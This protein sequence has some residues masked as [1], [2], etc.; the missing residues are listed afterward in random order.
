MFTAA[1]I[2]CLLFIFRFLIAAMKTFGKLSHFQGTL[3]LQKTSMQESVRVCVCVWSALELLD[4]LVSYV[5]TS[6]L[7]S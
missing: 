2:M 1:V 7:I 5:N 6:R 4:P 3:V